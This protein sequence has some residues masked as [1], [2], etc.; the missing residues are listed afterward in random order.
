MVDRGVLV[1]T[2]DRVGDARAGYSCPAVKIVICESENVSLS[3]PTDIDHDQRRYTSRGPQTRE[4]VRGIT[5]DCC[6]ISQVPVYFSGGTVG[7]GDAR[8]PVLIPYE[9]VLEVVRVVSASN[10]PTTIFRRALLGFTPEPHSAL[11]IV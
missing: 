7:M 2:V 1:W 9:V 3:R 8:V 10:N 11:C 4:R 5:H 6:S